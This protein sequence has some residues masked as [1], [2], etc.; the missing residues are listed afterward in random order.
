GPSVR[1]KRD[2][3]DLPRSEFLQTFELAAFDPVTI[4]HDLLA[5]MAESYAETLGRPLHEI[6]RWVEK[7]PANRNYIADILSRFSQAKLLVTIRDPRAVLAAQIAV[8]AK[9]SRK[10]FSIYYVVA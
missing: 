6:E 5:L 7:T 2:Y 8:T 10:D 3:S 9:R 1:G 4:D